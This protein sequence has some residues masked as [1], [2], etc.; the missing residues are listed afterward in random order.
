MR[1]KQHKKPTPQ[2]PNMKTK[3]NLMCNTQEASEQSLFRAVNISVISK[4]CILN[5]PMYYL[6]N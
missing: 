6:L 1:N 3:F 5:V 4:Y 2:A